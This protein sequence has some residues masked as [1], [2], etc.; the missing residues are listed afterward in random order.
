M[1]KLPYNEFIKSMSMFFLDKD[2]DNQYIEQRNNFSSLDEE[3]K[4]IN[5]RQG[6]ET[7]IRNNAASF[8]NLLVLLGVSGEYFKRIITLFRTLR[9][10]EF[11]T[12]WSIS[13]FRKFI[14]EDRDMMDKT[15]SLFIDADSNH[16]L[17]S[18]IPRFRLSMFKIT[19][20]V[21]SRLTNP[22]VLTLLFSKDLD[23]SFNNSMT[24]SK[25]KILENLLTSICR[26]HGYKLSKGC[27]IDVN[28]NNTRTIPVNFCITKPDDKFPAYY[29]CYSLYLTTSKGQTSFK[30][31]V[32]NLRD[33]IIRSNPDAKQI[34]I[35]DGAGWIGRQGDLQDVWD[36]SNYILNL[37]NIN[38]LKEI[39]K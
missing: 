1:A 8:D 23:T 34:T 4:H 16:E 20:A 26:L 17:V 31:N 11:R 15:I 22:D 30:N 28:G 36:Y 21:M 29:I 27:N 3:M 6:L 7:Y 18:L 35:V 37:N 25:I 13:A 9:G 33:F 19:P 38:E 2:I 32:K 39:I 14:L 24:Y 12:E 5:T 10:M